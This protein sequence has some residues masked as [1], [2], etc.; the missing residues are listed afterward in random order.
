MGPSHGA[1]Y[2]RPQLIHS[3]HR[4]ERLLHR[5]RG[6]KIVSCVASLYNPERVFYFFTSLSSSFRPPSKNRVGGPRGL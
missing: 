5:A 2:T 4:E 1:S 3:A 6:G